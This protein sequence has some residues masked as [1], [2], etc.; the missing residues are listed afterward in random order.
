MNKYLKC[1]LSIFLKRR[2][3]TPCYYIRILHYISINN[4]YYSNGVYVGLHVMG[5]KN[6]SEKIYPRVLS[7]LHY[8]LSKYIYNQQMVKLN[9][10]RIQ[11]LKYYI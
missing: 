10:I 11:P 1:Y 6:K 8:Y 9:N 7:D 4:K 2:V 3:Y 5:F